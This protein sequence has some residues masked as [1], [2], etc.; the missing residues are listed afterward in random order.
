[1][2]TYAKLAIGVAAVAVVAVVGIYLLPRS[3]TGVGG[4]PSALPSALPSPSPSPTSQKLPIGEVPPGRYASRWSGPSFTFTMPAGWRWNGE[5]IR[6]HEDEPAEIGWSTGGDVTRVYA[7]ACRSE[8]KLEPVGPT[9][10]DLV[11]ALEQQ[12]ETD[13]VVSDVTIGERAA[14]RVELSQGAGFN[15]TYCRYGE[16]GPLQIWADPG[17]TEFYALAPGHRG[18]VEV[19]DV[20]GDRLVLTAAIGPETAASDVAELES[21][22]DSIQFE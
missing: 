9:V 21:I 22:L 12:L 14:K 18:I 13:A 3:E 6:M 16:E 11:A 8:G 2:N 1:M 10:D 17:E 19:V 15:R 4:A 5:V 7:D 20:D